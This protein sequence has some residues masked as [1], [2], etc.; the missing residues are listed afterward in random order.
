MSS[1]KSTMSEPLPLPAKV[2]GH[3]KCLIYT[4]DISRGHGLSAPQKNETPNFTTLV[5][6]CFPKLKQLRRVATRFEK[7][8]R[9]Y[10][11]VVIIAA[12]IPWTR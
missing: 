4:S 7:T 5:E 11:A 10:L 9:N 6:C 1:V 12:A 2:L 8:A 3:A